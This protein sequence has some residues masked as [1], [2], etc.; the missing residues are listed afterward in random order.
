MDSPSPDDM[1]ALHI[2]CSLWFDECLP[3]NHPPPSTRGHE[4]VYDVTNWDGAPTVDVELRRNGFPFDSFKEI[5]FN[6]IGSFVPE[7]PQLQTMLFNANNSSRVEWVYSIREN[8]DSRM[9]MAKSRSDSKYREFLA[10]IRTFPDDAS[11]SIHIIMDKPACVD[12][13]NS[14]VSL[15]LFI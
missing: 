5:I 8:N 7:E 4:N 9:W 3:V 12:N 15:V 2:C 6:L 14:E 1:V 13:R 11:I 10:A